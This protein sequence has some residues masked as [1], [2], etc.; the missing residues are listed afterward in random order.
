MHKSRFLFSALDKVESILGEPGHG[1]FLLEDTIT[2]RNIR[3]FTTIV[4][5]NI[6]YFNALRCGL[7]FIWF[8]NPNLHKW[9]QL[10]KWDNTSI[11]YGAFRNTTFYDSVSYGSS[12]AVVKNAFA[13]ENSF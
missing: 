3:S 7:K 2:E 4:K 8:H 9:M 13:E 12:P 11:S 6:T 10:L 5:L 1:N